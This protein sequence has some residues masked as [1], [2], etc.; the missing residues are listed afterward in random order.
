MK[1]NPDNVRGILIEEC[2]NNL[3]PESM[4]DYECPDHTCIVW[5]L[6]NICVEEDLKIG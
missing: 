1:A 3:C 4:E 2:C 6:L 5:R